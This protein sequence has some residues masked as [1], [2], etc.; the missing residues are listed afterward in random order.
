RELQTC[1]YLILENNLTTALS[2]CQIGNEKLSEEI[3]NF[4]SQQPSIKSLEYTLVTSLSEDEINKKINLVENLSSTTT[5]VDLVI[6][7]NIETNIY[8]WEKLFSL[9][10]S[11]GFILVSSDIDV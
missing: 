8:D 7:N 6:V 11:N 10:K 3:F 2:L 5:A 9:C 4:Y 1:L